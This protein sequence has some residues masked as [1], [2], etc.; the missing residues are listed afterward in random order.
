MKSTWTQTRES[1]PRR[2]LETAPNG[3]ADHKAHVDAAF[4]LMAT[5]AGRRFVY[6]AVCDALVDP[7]RLTYEVALVISG[8]TRSEHIRAGELFATSPTSW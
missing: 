4:E 1:A 2:D 6:N 8:R 3:G 5:K 7:E